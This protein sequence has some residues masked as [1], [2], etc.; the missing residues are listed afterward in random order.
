MVE[1]KHRVRRERTW[2]S[3]NMW[4][5]SGFCFS[6]CKIRGLGRRCLS[7][8]LTLKSWDTCYIMDETWRHFAKW[9][10]P[11]AHG[12]SE[13]KSLSRVR[14]FVIPG[15]IRSMEFS[16]SMEWVIFPSSRGSSQSRDRTQVSRIVGGFFT[17]WVL[18]EAPDAN[19]HVFMSPFI[20]NVQ[21]KHI[22]R[23]RM[24]FS[25]CQGWGEESD[26]WRGPGFNLGW[27]NVPELDG[28]E[29]CATLWKYWRSRS[30]I[31]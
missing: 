29:D 24:W 2:V 13:W 1:K 12:V 18:R 30:Y 16:R 22:H 6:I 20:W 31:F 25:S 17:S 10:K 26:C 23:T 28:G 8:L 27:W 14:L 9:K 11:D 7:C 5:E 4:A 15:A 21:T 19:D 3:L